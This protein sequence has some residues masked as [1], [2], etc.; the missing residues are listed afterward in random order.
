MH[1]MIILHIAIISLNKV[2]LRSSC[3]LLKMTNDSLSVMTVLDV[4]IQSLLASSRDLASRNGTL[5]PLS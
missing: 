2:S 1:M 4:S 5:Q 3:C